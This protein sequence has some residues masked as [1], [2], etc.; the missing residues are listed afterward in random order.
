[1]NKYKNLLINLTFSF[2]IMYIVMFLNITK[3]SH[4]YISVTR[5]YM[6]LLMVF[7]MSILMILS[8]KDMYTEKKKNMTFILV[9]T[10]G[11]FITL[12]G[13]RNQIFVNDNQY[14]KAMIP[15][16]SSAI[17]VSENNTYKNPELDQLAKDIIKAQKREIELMQRLIK[18]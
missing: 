10:L 18:N 7:P 3:I 15:H 1:M 12:I 6:A 16:H 5:I 8:M 4:F 13:L 17:M 2:F 9:S 11:F 14:I